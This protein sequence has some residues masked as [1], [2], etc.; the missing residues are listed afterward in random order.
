VRALV[1]YCYTEEVAELYL[2]E[3]D[4]DPEDSKSLGNGRDRSLFLSAIGPEPLAAV[5]SS[6]E[7]K[8]KVSQET[9]VYEKARQLRNDP[10]LQSL[11]IFY[12]QVYPKE[13]VDQ[14]VNVKIEFRDWCHLSVLFLSGA[15]ISGYLDPSKRKK[16]TNW[17]SH[18]EEEFEER[19]QSTN[20]QKW[21]DRSVTGMAR[22]F[23]SRDWEGVLYKDEYP[24]RD[25]CEEEE[26]E[27]PEKKDALRTD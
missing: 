18:L 6:L 7:R 26:A 23:Y 12:S 3:I 19:I 22:Y 21:K 8:H 25:D 17:Y 4:W 24:S 11:Y 5:V 2:K 14:L 16:E 20:R 1:A 27:T 15:D 13:I 10:E 9:I